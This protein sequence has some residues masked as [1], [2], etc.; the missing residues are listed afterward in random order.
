MAALQ[1]AELQAQLP[2]TFQDLA[3]VT[4]L[5]VTAQGWRQEKGCKMLFAKLGDALHAQSR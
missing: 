4:V 3:S 1:G 2:S 5:H